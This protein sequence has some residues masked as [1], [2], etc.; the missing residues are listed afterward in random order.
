[1]LE[2]YRL[3][4]SLESEM[5]IYARIEALRM[6]GRTVEPMRTGCNVDCLLR[7]QLG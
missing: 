2:Q 1:M 5:H 3:I 7:W 6:D 4:V